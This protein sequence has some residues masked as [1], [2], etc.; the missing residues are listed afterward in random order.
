M[1]RHRLYSRATIEAAQLLGALVAVSRRERRWSARDLAE[2][3][4]ITPPTLRK[5]EQGDPTVSV[6]VAFEVA[7][8][9]G[10]PLFHEDG[11]RLTL[12][13]DRTR[14]RAAV[15]PRRVRMRVDGVKDDF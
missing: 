10:V 15:L 2:R 12:D 9:V 8:L 14:D 7:T 13:L 1:K 11:T 6:G 5:V 3:A 4:G